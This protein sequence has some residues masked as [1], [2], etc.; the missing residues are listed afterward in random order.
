M[1]TDNQ[2]KFQLNTQKMNAANKMPSKAPMPKND[3]NA[4]SGDDNGDVPSHLMEM[5][6]AMGGKHMHIHS[7][8]MGH[9]THHVTEDG[10]AHGPDEHQDDEALAEHVKGTMGDGGDMDGDQQTSPYGKESPLPDLS[11]ISA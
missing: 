9:T 1:P 8:G 3:M 11:G 6:K 10:E 2:G 7:H 4:T 5:H